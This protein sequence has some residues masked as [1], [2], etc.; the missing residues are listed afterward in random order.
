[1]AADADAWAPPTRM[2]YHI[3][4]FLA[5]NAIED[6]YAVIDG[7]DC[8][9]RKSQWVHAKHDLR[10]TLLD[11]SGRHR[12]INTLMD[13]EHVVTN[14]G[15]ALA[16]RLEQLATVASRGVALVCS[17]PHVMI[18]GTQYDKILRDLADRVPIPMIEVPSRSLEADWL[19]GYA[20]ALLAIARTMDV[21]DAKPRARHVAVIGHLM[22]RTEEDGRA[23]VRELRRLLEGLGLTVTSVWLDGGDYR[24]LLDARDAETLIALPLGVHAAR[25]LALRTGQ[26]VVEAPL[27]FGPGRTRRFLTAVARATDTLDALDPFVDDN[28]HRLVPR[29]ERAVPG[30]FQDRRVALSAPPFFWGGMLDM[31]AE[32]GMELVHLSA[33]AGDAWATEDLAA[34]FGPLPPRRL[35]YRFDALGRELEALHRERPIDLAI[36]DTRYCQRASWIAPVMEFGF[37]SHFDHA[38]HPRPTLGFE[39]WMCFLDRVAHALGAQRWA[40]FPRPHHAD[41]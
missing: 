11:A 29:I 41:G 27:P 16:L 26:K 38:L 6:A 24:Q 40:R 34:E 17:M 10:A 12:V 36:G 31:A 15:E 30:I 14:R 13:D 37:P 25:A 8:N 19:D 4:L 39:G 1:M 9:F 21:R 35:P 22:D 23:D 18:L 33:N 20:E 3:G 32:L 28:L 2:S 5:V 7:P